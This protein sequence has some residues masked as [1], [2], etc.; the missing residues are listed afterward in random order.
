MIF[1]A[2][3]RRIHHR[4]VPVLAPA[5]HKCQSRLNKPARPTPT[6]FPDMS[7]ANPAPLVS[8]K[9]RPLPSVDPVPNLNTRGRFV[10]GRRGV[11]TSRARGTEKTTHPGDMGA[12]QY[13]VQQGTEVHAKLSMFPNKLRIATPHPQSPDS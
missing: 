9:S 3:I 5:F 4:F 8:L 2:T 12:T 6:D 7:L 11:R 13:I 10:E 1:I